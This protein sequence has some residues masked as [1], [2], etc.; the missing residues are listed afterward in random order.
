MLKDSKDKTSKHDCIQN[1]DV[2]FYK[3]AFTINISKY[4][5]NELEFRHFICFEILL[6]NTEAHYK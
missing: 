3:F 1:F 5:L 6:C 2:I 4:Y